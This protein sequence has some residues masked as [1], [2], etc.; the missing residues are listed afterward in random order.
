[1]PWIARGKYRLYYTLDGDPGAPLLIFSSSLGADLRMWDPQVEFLKAFFRILRYDHPG[2]GQSNPFPG[3]PDISD[4]GKDVLVLMDELKI[5]KCGFCGLSLG[6]MTGLW[7]AANAPGRFEK[8]AV[9]STAARIENPDLLRGRIRAIRSGGLASVTGSVVQN[10]FTPE[11]VEKHPL[12]IQEALEMLNRTRSESYA[13]LAETVCG[14]DLREDLKKIRL[15]LMIL[16]G[17]ED[18]ATPPAWNIALHQ[19]IPTS[20]LYELPGAH[21]LNRQSPDEFSKKLLEFFLTVDV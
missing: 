1:M 18:K 12:V 19:L 3:V 17:K 15:P 20:T 13:A 9:S 14:L 11:F 6:G 10:W 4:L 7:L 16:Y 21:L 2:H 5:E 8:I